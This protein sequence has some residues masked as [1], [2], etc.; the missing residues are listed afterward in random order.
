MN[1]IVT[2]NAGFVGRNLTARLL[3]EGHRV[4]GFDRN[5]TEDPFA[6]RHRNFRQI[7]MDIRSFESVRK[8]SGQVK[9]AK[10]VFHTAAIQ[11]TGTSMEISEYLDTNVAG[12]ANLARV[13]AEY[14]FENI[15]VSSSFSVY[16]RPKYLPMDEKHPAEPINVY[17][18]SKLQA[19]SLFA[20]YARKTGLKVA[21]LRYDGIYGAGQ[22]ISGFYQYLVNSFMKKE[23]VVLF[24]GGKQKRDNVYIDDV[25][26]SNLEAMKYLKRVNYG[27]FNIGGGKASTA[28][29]KAKAV[30]GLIGSDSKIIL[31]REKKRGMN[32][33]VYMS[34]SK[35][36]KTLGYK[37]KSTGENLERM[38]EETLRNE[39][40]V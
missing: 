12:A 35:A 15:V 31:H 5:N 27:I 21:I 6:L 33:D 7:K 39:K 37:P 18:L 25:V 10:Y 24:N 3:K 40:A 17:G 38:I 16:G 22:T 14:G 13:C 8:S 11:P 1:V 36:R 32:Y 20:F 34:N 4:Y 28:L 26:E 2:G 29:E 30:K 19:E 9:S 23:D